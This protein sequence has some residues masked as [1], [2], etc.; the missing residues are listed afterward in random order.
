M[1]LSDECGNNP[2]VHH[3]LLRRELLQCWL[4]GRWTV[5][6]FKLG[7]ASSQIL[8]GHTLHADCMKVITAARI[9]LVV[10][11]V[12]HNAQD[13][14]KCVPC[15]RNRDRKG[16]AVHY[17]LTNVEKWRYVGIQKAEYNCRGRTDL[18]LISPKHMS[19]DS[20]RNLGMLSARCSIFLNQGRISSSLRT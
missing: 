11:S 16:W 13:N 6:R 7:I 9:Q 19:T 14:T 1:L 15:T 17:M 3:F 4:F 18:Y 8:F 10:S 12:Q 20:I 5:I 2:V